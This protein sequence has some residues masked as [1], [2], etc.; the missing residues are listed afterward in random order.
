MLCYIKFQFCTYSLFSQVMNQK[1][2]K[3]QP[4]KLLLTFK[5]YPEDVDDLIQTIT[6]VRSYFLQILFKIK[7]HCSKSSSFCVRIWG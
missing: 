3:T 5:F 4:I 2:K 1:I 7:S 6:K